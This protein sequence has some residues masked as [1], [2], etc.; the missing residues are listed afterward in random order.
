M[1]YFLAGFMLLFLLVALGCD[2]LTDKDKQLIKDSS[3][4]LDAF[5]KDME[6]GKTTRKQEKAWLRLINQ[7]LIEV[8]KVLEGEKQIK[9]SSCKSRS[10]P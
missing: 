3:V 10:G 4:V 2:S 7:R 8:T 9:K 1:K 6:K 5:V